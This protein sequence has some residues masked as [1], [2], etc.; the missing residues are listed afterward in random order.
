MSN[1]G[2]LAGI[3]RQR[4]PVPVVIVTDTLSILFDKVGTTTYFGWAVPGTSE[5][6]A[7]WRILRT[8]KDTSAL[9]ADGDKNFDNV[10]TNRA[11][12]SY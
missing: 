3:N 11:S 9:W 6:A 4:G 12:L 5:S 10:W 8:I 2:L 1:T 7:A